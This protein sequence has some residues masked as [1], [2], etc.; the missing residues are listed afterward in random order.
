ML[1]ADTAIMKPAPSA[2]PEAPW[3]PRPGRLLG[4]VLVELGLVE[5]EVVE[6][7]VVQAR[8]SGRPMGQVLLDL[9][10]LTPDELAGAVSE[11]FGLE[12][13]RLDT[14]AVDPAAAN[15]I[16]PA[17]ARRLRALPVAFGEGRVLLVAMVNPANV[18]AVDDLAM[19]TDHR[20][21]PVVVSEEDLQ[22]LVARLSRL[23]EGIVEA[24]P[25]AEPEP[26]L[27]LRDGGEDAPTIR[28]VHS[29]IAQA[30]DQGAS[31]VHFDPVDGELQ[32]RLRIDGVMVDAARVPR[33][34]APKVV[35]RVKILADLDISERRVPQDGRVGMTVDGRRIDL[36]VVT[37]PL[38][39]GESVVLRVLDTG[40]VPLTLNELGMGAD[41]RERLASVLGRSY[42]AMLATGLTGSGKSTS[43]YAAL[44]TVRSGE[45]TI[46]SIEDPVEYRLPRVKQV[47]VNDRAGLT[48]A[49]GL[50][51]MMRAD[52]DVIMVGEMRDRES[53]QIAVE[54]ALTGHLVLST[55]HTRDAPSA[56]TRLVDMGIE[57]F[58]VAS[59]IDCVVAQRLA[60]RLCASCRRPTEVPAALVGLEGDAPVPVFEPLGCAR[61]RGT[62]YR[63]RVGL[64]EVMTV[65]EELRGLIVARAPSD[66]LAEAAVR[67]GM[68]RLRDDGLAKVRRGETSLAELARVSG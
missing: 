21:Q 29:V 47:Q 54:A 57:P 24:E 9:G 4:D 45:K 15:L 37:V 51:S 40:G 42:G 1:P 58:L 30:V 36:R 59:S 35:S 26:A 19:I 7:A 67:A 13:L 23:D 16:A 20:V 28:L 38:V 56:I 52:P 34:L 8:G 5:R 25:E 60:R 18:L 12:H 43:L 31:D 53:A 41:D 46:M 39:A 65:G 22:A 32:V 66:A 63:G 2:I 44:L 50:R 33:S 11:R 68:R 6:H 64:F 3:R 62:G 27:D 61:C 48:F 55:L 17:V 10:A 49:S 14:F